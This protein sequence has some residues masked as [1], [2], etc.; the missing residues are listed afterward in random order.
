MTSVH[1]LLECDLY[2]NLTFSDIICLDDVLRDQR[3]HRKNSVSFQVIYGFP[4]PTISDD[5]LDSPQRPELKWIDVTTNAIL[6]S[7]ENLILSME[8]K[9]ASGMLKTDHPNRQETFITAEFLNTKVKM[10]LDVLT[11]RRINI[12]IHVSTKI[13]CVSQFGVRDLSATVSELS[14][15]ASKIDLSHPV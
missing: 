2:M 8:D 3:N 10:I 14:L 5:G 1:L 4:C 9:K 6:S 7:S 12:N 11:P 13:K 15:C